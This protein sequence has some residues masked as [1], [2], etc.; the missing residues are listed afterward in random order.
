MSENK[1]LRESILAFDDIESETV[2]VPQWGGIKVE[3]RGMSGKERA[4]L[5]KRAMV[6]GELD[7]ERLYPLLIVATV[8]DP[9]SGDKVFSEKDLNALNEKSGAALEHVGK[10]AAR[11]SGM[12]QEAADDMGKPSS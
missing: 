6:D 3:V 11:L 5:M 1:S 9:E 2:E 10:V 4:G 7:F 8:F 12:N